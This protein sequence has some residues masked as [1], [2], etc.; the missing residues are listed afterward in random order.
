MGFL[1]F[2]IGKL[3][4]MSKLSSIFA[5]I[6]KALNSSRKTVVTL[7]RQEPVLFTKE[8]DASF[9]AA[10]ESEF[11]SAKPAQ[12]LNPAYLNAITHPGQA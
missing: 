7:K 6:A 10:L 9:E 11:G 3:S 8:Q 5:P 2:Y 12:A 4:M 1:H